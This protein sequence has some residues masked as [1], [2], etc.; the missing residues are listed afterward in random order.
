VER[1]DR[2]NFKEYLVKHQLVNS[3]FKIN[4]GFDFMIEA[5][6]KQIKDMDDFLENI[7]S[8]FKIEDKN[9]FFIIEDLKREAFMSDPNLNF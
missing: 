7:E 5:V 8:K 3:I 4:N 2:N 9:S 1:E 6:F